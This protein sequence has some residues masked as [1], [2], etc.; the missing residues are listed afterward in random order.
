MLWSQ[1]TSHRLGPRR[2]M[3]SEPGA[4]R[5]EAGRLGLER[6][7]LRE[8]VPSV[9]QRGCAREALHPFVC[10]SYACCKKRRLRRLRL[11]FVCVRTT[12]VVA[13][14]I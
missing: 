12:T 11:P 6:A 7:P 4:A 1:A 9:L 3:R 2:A 8:H 10:V 5:G 14:H 13:A